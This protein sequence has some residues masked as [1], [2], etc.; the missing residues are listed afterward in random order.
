MARIPVGTTGWGKKWLDSLTG[1]D[2]V[3][4]LP[5]GRSYFNAGRVRSVEFDPEER[6]FSARV[7]GS[8]GG[9]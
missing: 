6:V 5:R 2:W 3:N 7:Q 8:R 9:P 4:R 1:L